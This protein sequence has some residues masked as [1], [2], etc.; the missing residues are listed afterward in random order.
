MCSRGGR[1]HAV[2]RRG[3]GSATGRWKGPA[4]HG[5]DGRGVTVWREGHGLDAADVS[6]SGALLERS[7]AAK[8]EAGLRASLQGGRGGLIRADV[9][10][11]G[12]IMGRRVWVEGSAQGGLVAIGHGV[13]RHVLGRL[14]LDG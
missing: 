6:C 10:E 9:G 8:E 5:D 1:D 11:G 13:R 7:A 12:Q 3:R 2:W 4:V 14:W